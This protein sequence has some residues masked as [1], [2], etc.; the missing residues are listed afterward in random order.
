MEECEHL[1]I[2]SDF[3][4]ECGISIS[5]TGN[6]ISV[7]ESLYKHEELDKVFWDFGIDFNALNLPQEITERVI[8]IIPTI[9]KTFY[10]KGSKIK[11]L[12][13]LIYM[14]YICLNIDFDPIDLSKKMKL[15]SEDILQCIKIISGRPGTTNRNYNKQTISMVVLQPSSFIRDILKLLPELNCLDSDTLI[16]NLDELVI[17]NE[18]LLEENPKD[19]ACA[20]I[21][22]ITKMKNIK[23]ANY[24]IKVG[25]TKNKLKDKLEIFNKVFQSE[26]IN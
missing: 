4:L 2:D 21:M 6:Y 14:S 8:K 10:R 24:H 9:S 13:V 7:D 3:C 25:I 5:S 11:S 19:I 12:Y 23:L 22:Y 18:Y 26:K 17:E 15:T 16:K 20:Y 1:Y